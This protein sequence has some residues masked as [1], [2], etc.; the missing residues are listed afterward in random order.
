MP[1]R[2]AA[3]T[4]LLALLAACGS[5]GGASTTPS[6]TPRSDLP[7]TATPEPTAVDPSAIVLSWTRAGGIAGL[8]D[9]LLMTAGHRAILG[10]CEQ[11]PSPTASGDLAP[12]ESIIEFERWRSTY[13]SFE[14]EWDD[15]PDVADGMRIELAFVGRGTEPAGE[16]VQRQIADFAARLYAESAATQLRAAAA[17]APPAS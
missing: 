5:D 1:L 10:T 17:S 2:L 14:V 6:P 8:C 9:G 11:P 12:G 15:G 13:A 16:D 3:T 7:R 4:L